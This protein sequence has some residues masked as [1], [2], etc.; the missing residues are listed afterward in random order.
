MLK[1]RFLPD[2]QS[3][4]S[5]NGKVTQAQFYDNKLCGPGAILVIVE[6]HLNMLI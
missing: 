3:E 2:Y 6:E 1:I 4:T 5:R